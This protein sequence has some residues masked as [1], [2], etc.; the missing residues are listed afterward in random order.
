MQEAPADTR[1]DIIKMLAEIIG[2]GTESCEAGGNTASIRT[3]AYACGPAECAGLAQQLL[4]LILE[5]LGK[6]ASLSQ[7]PPT[8]AWKI[9][10]FEK[11]YGW[12]TRL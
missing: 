7:T 11:A 6:T 3:A 10:R 8:L 12:R 2:H 5:L 9:W 1:K 4:T